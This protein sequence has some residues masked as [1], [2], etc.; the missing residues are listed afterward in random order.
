MFDFIVKIRPL[1]KT[2]LF[3]FVL[4][5]RFG[6]HFI[7]MDQNSK[8]KYSWRSELT[9]SF[10]FK[11]AVICHVLIVAFKQGKVPATKEVLVSLLSS[12]T[13]PGVHIQTGDFR[14]GEFEYDMN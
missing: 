8:L 4:F 9:I 13:Q 6:F 2:S 3:Q 5:K 11:P 7:G 14:F 10:G 12:N 1:N